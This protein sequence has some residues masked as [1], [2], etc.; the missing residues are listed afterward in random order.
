MRN[1]LTKVAATALLST[2]AVMSMPVGSAAASPRLEDPGWTLH[3]TRSSGSETF[4]RYVHT[5][6]LVAW[7]N[8]PLSAL[9]RS[10]RAQ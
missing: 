1:A 4:Y 5:S 7:T 8:H 10:T 2:M 3:S 9:P 6:G